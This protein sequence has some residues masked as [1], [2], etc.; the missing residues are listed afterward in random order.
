MG[1]EQRGKKKYYYRSRWVNRRVVKEY[2]GF[3]PEA[4]KE[5]KAKAKRRADLWALRMHLQKLKDII[6]PLNE[7][8]DLYFEAAMYAAGYHKPN[9]GPWRKRRVKRD[10]P[11]PPES[12][13]GSQPVPKTG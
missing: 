2:V 12:G 13:T 10:K 8:A 4:E 11:S 5:A 3:G 6:A 7:L 1:W 9:R